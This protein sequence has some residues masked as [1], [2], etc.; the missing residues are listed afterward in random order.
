MRFEV[1][2]LNLSKKIMKCYN[3]NIA[4]YGIETERFGK[5]IRNELESF[6]ISC[7]RWG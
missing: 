2:H 4:L 5:H 3:W 1:D 7:W 6:E